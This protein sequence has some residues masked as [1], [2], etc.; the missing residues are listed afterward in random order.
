MMKMIAHQDEC[1]LRRGMHRTLEGETTEIA[2][3]VSYEISFSQRT[4][5]D[6]GT[7]LFLSDTRYG[8]SVVVFCASNN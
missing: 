8:V 5:C 6:F 1:M 3:I 4:T 2:E 7:N